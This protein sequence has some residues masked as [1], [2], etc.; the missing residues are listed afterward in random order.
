MKTSP[1]PFAQL[2]QLLRDLHFAEARK[3][4][5]WRFEH[6]VSGTIFLFRPY[7][8]DE[9]VNMADLASVQKQLDWRGLLPA[10]SFDNLLTKTPA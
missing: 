10:S 2:R 5:G 9:K 6:P 4:A 8:P 1:I 3:E 7:T